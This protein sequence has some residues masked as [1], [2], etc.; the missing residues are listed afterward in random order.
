MRC[1][2]AV[3][4][5]R[6]AFCGDVDFV[7]FRNQPPCR[8]LPATGKRCTDVVSIRYGWARISC[9]YMRCHVWPLWLHG[10]FLVPTDQ[11]PCRRLPA[12]GKRCTDVVSIRHGWARISCGKLLQ[13]AVFPLHFRRKMIL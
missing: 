4:A 7:V 5:A 2:V 8:R 6:V 3:M 11:P 9:G 13:V 1:Y 12:T 10:W